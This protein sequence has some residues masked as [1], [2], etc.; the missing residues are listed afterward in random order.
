WP[1]VHFGSERKSE[2]RAMVP[3]LVVSGHTAAAAARALAEADTA[4]SASADLAVR[5]K[6]DL[7]AWADEQAAIEMPAP[8]TRLPIGRHQARVVHRL[9]WAGPPQAPPQRPFGGQPRRGC[10]PPVPPQNA[11]TLL[12]C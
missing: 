4:P 8:A 11:G 10:P 3:R 2:R 6:P 9:V 7:Y 5:V 1:P 12:V